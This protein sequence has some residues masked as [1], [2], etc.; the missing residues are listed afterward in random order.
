[1]LRRLL[2]NASFCVGT[3]LLS[4]ATVSSAVALSAPSGWQQQRA[5]GVTTFTPKKLNGKPFSLMVSDPMP[6]QGL[7]LS[8]WAPQA[9]DSVSSS[10]G[11]VVSRGKPE[12]NAPLWTVQHEVDVNGRR[13]SAVYHAFV[14]A[15]DQ[16]RLTVMLGDP[17]AFTR[18]VPKAADIIAAAL[19][20]SQGA[21]GSRKAGNAPAEAGA[22]GRKQAAKAASDDTDASADKAPATPSEGRQGKNRFAFSAGDI[23]TILN[24]A[25]TS[26]DVYGLEVIETTHVLLKDG[27]LYTNGKPNGSWRKSGKRYQYQAAK[28][29]KGWQTL[30]GDP[31]LGVSAKTLPG[32]YNADRGHSFGGTTAVTKNRIYFYPDGRYETDHYFS[33]HTQM[34]DGVTTPKATTA[35]GKGKGIRQGRYRLLNQYAIELKGDDGSV[36]QVIAYFTDDKR[37]WLNL[38]ETAYQRK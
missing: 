38:N 27:R 37:E 31:T 28:G 9:V 4:L 35:V 5:Q 3:L 30:N 8:R 34:G 1:M 15:P 12:F 17:E 26:Y 32:S 7:S 10:Y 21:S 36:R 23:Q 24:H 2:I 20:E 19:A 13:F 16:A 18:H 29:N 25:E 11:K 14:H 33:G 22:G 6:M